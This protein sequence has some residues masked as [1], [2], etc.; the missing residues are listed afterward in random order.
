MAAQTPAAYIVFDV[1]SLDGVDLR[2]QPWRR[3]RAVLEELFD[4]QGVPPGLVLIPAT[5]SV[6]V[7]RSWMHLAA[8]GTG[9]E[10]VVAKKVASS[11]RPGR[12]H[13][14]AWQKIRA[15]TTG[16][17]LIGGVTG[18]L[19]APETL[20]LGRY[21]GGRLRIAGR[22]TALP[23]AARRAVG[24]LLHPGDQA[25]PVTL[26]APRWD[27]PRVG[28]ERVRPEVV[29]EV[30]ADVSVT[31]AAWRNPARFVRVRGDLRPEDLRGAG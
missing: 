27:A 9:I 18:P 29:V 1:L 28:Y 16:E 31:G 13:R 6:D 14:S 22:T 3:R 11:Y 26:P 21:V 2:P 4:Q 17:A 5:P 7:A 30:S 23:P 12:Q 8:A 20:I 19:E 10:G 15:R 24:A 25:W